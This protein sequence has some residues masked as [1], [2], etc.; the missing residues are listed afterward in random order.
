M[1]KLLLPNLLQLPNLAAI[2]QLMIGDILLIETDN[3]QIRYFHQKDK[4][5]PIQKIST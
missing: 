3:I 2:S 1:W 5:P 4:D